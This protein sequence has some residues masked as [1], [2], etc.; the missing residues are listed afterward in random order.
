MPRLHLSRPGNTQRH[1]AVQVNQRQ[2]VS[3]P[4]ARIKC[5]SSVAKPSSDP[6]A[7]PQDFASS[8]HVGFPLEMANIPVHNHAPAHRERGLQ[9]HIV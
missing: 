9:L 3:A 1:A 7:A 6:S 2:I 8:Q 5:L 4:T